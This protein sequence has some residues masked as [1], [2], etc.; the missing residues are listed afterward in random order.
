MVASKYVPILHAT[1]AI[2]VVP[3]NEENPYGVAHA[4]SS[5]SCLMHHI[6]VTALV[7]GI[8]R[9]NWE[10]QV[11]DYHWPNLSEYDL[12]YKSISE[13]DSVLSVVQAEIFAVD[14]HTLDGCQ[15]IF[16]LPEFIPVEYGG[17]DASEKLTMVKWLPGLARLPDWRNRVRLTSVDADSSN[18]LTNAAVRAI[19]QDD[20]DSEPAPDYDEISARYKRLYEKLRPHELEGLPTFKPSSTAIPLSTNKDLLDAVHNRLPFPKGWGR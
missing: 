4:M 9:T 11:R 13:R 17:E 19:L 2:G 14:V 6:V 7:A 16:D 15:E 18:T 1:E 12:Q 10:E 8:G 3:Y 5:G 20:L